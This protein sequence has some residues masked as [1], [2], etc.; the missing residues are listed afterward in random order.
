M[1]PDALLDGFNEAKAHLPNYRISTRP[2][3][4]V[5]RMDNISPQEPPAD[6][7]V[8]LNW[9]FLERKSVAALKAALRGVADQEQLHAK[10]QSALVDIE[11]VGGLRQYL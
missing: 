8:V 5:A 4:R 9:A 11:S 2:T 3:H 1:N 6:P 10:F 7:T